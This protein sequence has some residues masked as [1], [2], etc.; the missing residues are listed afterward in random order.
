MS[1]AK[2]LGEKR[3]LRNHMSLPRL[4][5]AQILKWADAH[6]ERTGEWPNVT[7]GKVF[8]APGETWAGIKTALRAGTRGLPG[9]SSLAKLL[10]ARRGVRSKK[11]LPALTIKRILKWVDAH[12]TR[13]G[14]WPK[15]NSGGVLDAPGETWRGINDALMRGR[16]GLPGGSSL[17]K[18]LA[19]HRGVRR[20]VAGIPRQPRS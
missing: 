16:R 8:K 20:T 3:G 14:M 6:H 17:A 2:V 11:A 10:A 18:L 5:T 12:K 15:Q 13:T 19:E 4:T 9:G 7:S 1:L